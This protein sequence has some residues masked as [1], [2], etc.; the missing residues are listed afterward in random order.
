ME[1]TL[2]VS[3]VRNHIFE[4]AMRIASREGL[5]GLSIGVL[6]KAVGM[7]K[8]GLFAHVISKDRLQLSVLQIATKDFTEK[9]LSKAFTNQ[10]GEPRVRALFEHWIQYLKDSTT[11]PGG[12]ILIT[13]AMEL[14]DKPGELRDYIQRIQALLLGNLSKAARISIETGHFRQDLDTERFA[15]RMYSYVL[16][17]HHFRQVMGE[18]Q[19]EKMARTSFEEFLTQ[20]RVLV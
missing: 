16:G 10:K 7:S 11:L 13:S 19:A 3:Q 5:Q 8:S 9:V 12:E 15:W 14:D 20:S 17:F 6:A 2:K 18:A 4:T 1:V